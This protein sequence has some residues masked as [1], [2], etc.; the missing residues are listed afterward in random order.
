MTPPKVDGTPKPASSVMIKRIFGASFGGT[1]RGAHQGVELRASFLMTPPKA[2]SGGGSCFPS[3]VVVAL[4]D[5]GVPVI[6]WAIAGQAAPE[7]SANAAAID[8]Q[9][10]IVDHPLNEKMTRRY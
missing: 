3:I 9:L 2:G 10:F 7:A 4:G 6:V 5:P 8:F 1:I